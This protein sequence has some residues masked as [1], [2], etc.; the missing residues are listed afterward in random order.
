MMSRPCRLQ[1]FSRHSLVGLTAA[2]LILVLVGVAN[3]AGAATLDIAGPPGAEI[4]LDGTSLGVLPLAGPVMTAAG[5]HELRCDLTGY[6]VYRQHIV[7]HNQDEQLLISIRLSP[8]SRRTAI[9]SNVLLAG[10]GPHY[11]GHH[12][13]GWLYNAA[14]IGGLL[15]A[16]AGELRRS[17]YRKDYLLLQD[18]YNAAINAEEIATLRNATEKA[19]ADMEDMETVR[20]AGMAVAGGAIVLSMI[21][22]WLSFPNLAIGP[23]TLPVAS[24]PFHGNRWPALHA[25]VRLGF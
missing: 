6:I 2:L 14:E 20:N 10:L 18:Q 5:N 8:L 9:G 4:F 16:L 11:L 24:A 7:L 22:A 1:D 3:W 21:D 25:G 13:R 15:T 17:D 12:T 23:G 19:Y